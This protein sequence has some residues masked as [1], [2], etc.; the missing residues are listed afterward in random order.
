M[1][2]SLWTSARA[3]SRGGSKA[4]IDFNGAVIISFWQVFI[5]KKQGGDRHGK[6]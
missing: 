1:G 6:R 5:P 3:F 2:V 4:D